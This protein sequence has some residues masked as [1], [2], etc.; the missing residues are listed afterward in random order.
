MASKNDKKDIDEEQQREED[1]SVAAAL[2]AVINTIDC[3]EDA[4][5]G[6]PISPLSVASAST[7]TTSKRGVVPRIR[8]PVAEIFNELGPYYQQRSYRMTTNSFYRLHRILS[9]SLKRP[10]RRKASA[11]APE[12]RNGAPNG[13]VCSTIRLAVALRFF[14]GASPYDMAVCHGVSV[15]EVYR[16]VWYVVNAVNRSSS[17]EL[18][19]EFPSTHDEQ[20]RLAKGFEE[21]SEANFHC[22]IAAIDGILI[23]TECPTKAECELAKCGPKKFFCGRKHKFGLNMMGTVDYEGRFVDVQISHPAATSDYLAFATS[24]LKSKLEQSGFLAPGLVL[25]GDNAYGN[26]PY[27]VTPFKGKVTEDQ[28][29]FNFYHSQL[30][31]QVECSFGQLV[32]RWGILRRPLSPRF[33]IKR[34]CN[35]VLALC[36]LHNFCTNRRLPVYTPMASDDVY[37]A[38][39]SSGINVT[40]DLRRT[41]AANNRENDIEGLLDGGRHFEDSNRNIRRQD[42]RRAL[43]LFRSGSNAATGTPPVLPQQELFESVVN[44]GLKRP[45]PRSWN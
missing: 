43:R 45:R 19:I 22:C 12:Q 39:A 24:D 9:P 3:I 38:M 40:G 1:V 6:I 13:L 23:W 2:F 34:T 29:A 20:N 10:A 17:S 33:G 28:D 30:R 21:K 18:K 41:T 32:H 31:I 36:R 11:S 7:A 26:S 5:T 4:T 37:I 35:L 25:F 42:T 27:M 8:R 16:S 14:A 15:K 44:Q